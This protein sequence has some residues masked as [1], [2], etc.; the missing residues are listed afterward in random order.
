MPLMTTARTER[1]RGDRRPRS[2]R[3]RYGR[4]IAIVL[5]VKMLALIAIWQLW[6]A[7]PT[8]TSIDP[9][10]IAE[11]IYSSDGSAAPDND[12]HARP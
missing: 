1:I 2:G 6:F 10:R 11:R 12:R 9:Q 5:V 4:E 3:S 7:A 8:R